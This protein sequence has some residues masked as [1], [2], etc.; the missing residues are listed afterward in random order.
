M[1]LD[2]SFLKKIMDFKNNIFLDRFFYKKVL[3]FQGHALC[4]GCIFLTLLLCLLA[5]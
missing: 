4:G 3:A 1:N 5:L 2:F